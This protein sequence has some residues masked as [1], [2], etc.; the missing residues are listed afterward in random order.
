MQGEFGGYRIRPPS[1]GETAL[2]LAAMTK[3]FSIT[4]GDHGFGIAQ[5]CLDLVAGLR[6][7]PCVAVEVINAEDDLGDFL[8]GCAVPVSVE[9][10]QHSALPK[11]L[12]ARQPRVGRN[13]PAVQRRQEA[14]DGFDPVEAL[15]T[16][17][18]CGDRVRVAVDDRVDDLEMLSGFE[19]EAIR[20]PVATHRRIAA[21]RFRWLAHSIWIELT[22]RRGEHDDACILPRKPEN[23]SFRRW[24]QGIDREIATPIAVGSD[25]PAARLFGG[26]R[27]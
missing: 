9:G 17:R 7:L 11:A 12:L 18:D 1:E 19:S 23:R 22:R 26:R 27:P 24:Y 5:E 6:R 15:N 16:E 20:N 3:E 21:P 4:A 14:I 8:L 2:G 13:G 10:A 25:R